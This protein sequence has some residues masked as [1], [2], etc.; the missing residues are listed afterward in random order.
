[1]VLFLGLLL[2]SYNLF[3]CW[4]TD[5]DL[6]GLFLLFLLLNSRCLFFL[7]WFFLDLFSS[8]S[9]SFSLLLLLGLLFFHLFHHCLILFLGLSSFVLPK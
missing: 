2:L 3:L 4:L 7:S 1:M 8:S 5:S 6:S 9:F